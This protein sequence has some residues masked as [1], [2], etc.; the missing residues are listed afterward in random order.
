[1]IHE[2][3]QFLSA[4]VWFSP[5][6]VRGFIK[7]EVLEP[8]GMDTKDVVSA[9]RF[10]FLWHK[11][12][13]MLLNSWS[14]FTFSPDPVHPLW[15]WPAS[16]RPCC[17]CCCCPC[18]PCCSRR[19]SSSCSSCSGCPSCSCCPCKNDYILSHLSLLKNVSLSAVNHI[20]GLIAF[21]VQ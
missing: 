4:C 1:M 6:Q 20:N 17:T 2:V 9:C 11:L 12:C 10:S 13:E 5:P 14:F 8:N 18:C 7:Q 16:C 21:N 3:P 15:I 19:R